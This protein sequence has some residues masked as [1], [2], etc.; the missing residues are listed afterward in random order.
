MLCKKNTPDIPLQEYVF[1]QYNNAFIRQQE[2]ANKAHKDTYPCS[3]ITR[4]LQFFVSFFSEIDSVCSLTHYKIRSIS[5]VLNV[6][7]CSHFT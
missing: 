3:F 1:L 7:K 4:L 2:H 5:K 6:N